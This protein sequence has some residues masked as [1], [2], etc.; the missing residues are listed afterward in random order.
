M[1]IMVN[2]ETVSAAGLVIGSTLNHSLSRMFCTS[3]AKSSR[4]VSSFSSVDKLLKLANALEAAGTPILGTSPDTLD[5]AEDRERFVTYQRTPTQP[6]NGGTGEDE[7]QRVASW[8]ALSYARVGSWRAMEVVSDDADLRRYMT[9][10]VQVGGY[11]VLIDQFLQG[12]S[13][14]TLTV[15]QR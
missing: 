4:S 5:R 2:Y 1:T 12:R 15:F 13:S 10:A 7:A 11:P 3:C 14:W 9:E 6:R 8:H